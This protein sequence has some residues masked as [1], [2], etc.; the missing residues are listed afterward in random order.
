MD[1]ILFNKLVVVQSI[2]ILVCMWMLIHYNESPLPIILTVCYVAYDGHIFSK[3]S[4]FFFF[5]KQ[6]ISVIP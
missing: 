5:D 4:D 1:K 3:V 6:I 2:A